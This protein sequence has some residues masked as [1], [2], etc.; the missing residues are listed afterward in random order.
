[1]DR[2]TLGQLTNDAAILLVNQD[3]LTIVAGSYVTLAGSVVLRVVCL[4]V[5]LAFVVLGSLRTL[6]EGCA[7][8]Q[9]SLEGVDILLRD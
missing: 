3:N 7:L 9:D 1:M 4:D 2:S 6:K 8:C 5:T